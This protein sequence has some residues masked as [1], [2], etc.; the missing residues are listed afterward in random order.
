MIPIPKEVLAPLEPP[1]V[2]GPNTETYIEA[3]L[4]HHTR[5]TLSTT[6]LVPVRLGL[7][8]RKVMLVGMKEHKRR[9]SL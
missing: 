4:F 3:D 9:I 6:S 1:A 2:V 5:R 7:G 8:R